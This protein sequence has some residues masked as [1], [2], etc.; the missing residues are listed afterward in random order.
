MEYKEPLLLLYGKEPE[1]KDCT[2]LGCIKGYTLWEGNC[3]LMKRKDPLPKNVMTSPKVF[4]RRN[5]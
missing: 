4:I 2:F 3:P 5:K 1:C